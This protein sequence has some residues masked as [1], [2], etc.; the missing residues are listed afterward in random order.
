VCWKYIAL[1]PEVTDV[2]DVLDGARDEYV[3][4]VRVIAGERGPA[5]LVA[6]VRGARVSGWRDRVSGWRL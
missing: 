1:G 6:L 2:A 5:S 3:E 4:A